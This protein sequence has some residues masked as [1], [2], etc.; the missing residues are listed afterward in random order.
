MVETSSRV[1]A[2]SASGRATMTSGLEVPRRPRRDDV[3]VM[4]DRRPTDPA[5]ARRAIENPIAV[6]KV[7]RQV[8]VSA[9]Q[10]E[11]LFVAYFA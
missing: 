7:A 11:R 10:L 9:R 1:L 3:V 8:G 6:S 5:S 4:A 2:R